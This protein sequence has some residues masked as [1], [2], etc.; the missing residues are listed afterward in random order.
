MPFITEEVWQGFGVGESIVVAEWPEAHPEHRDEESEIRF[1]F[2]EEL[3]TAIRR[4]RKHHGLADSMSLAARV[5]ST[6]AQR[7]IVEGMRDEI[8]RL[9]N[10]STLA[11]LDEPGD[12]TGC[13]RLV[14]DGAQ[15]LIPLAGVLDPE[16]E[17]SRL[18]KRIAGI[19]QQAARS[20]GKL[21]S[22][23]F[24]S[25]APPE[26]VERERSRLAALKEEAAALFSQLEELG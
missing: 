23:G 22:E 8:Q 7:G 17:R 9:A 11:V 10:V 5:H 24:V 26:V 1:G 15:V 2:A 4:F 25:K 16:V 20:E 12:P 13:A 18:S 19:E 6:P 21:S 3:V 14:A